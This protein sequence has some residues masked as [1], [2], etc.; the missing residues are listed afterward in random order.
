MR[1]RQLVFIAASSLMMAGLLFAGSFGRNAS[2]NAYSVGVNAYTIGKV[3]V[4]PGTAV[5]GGSV[6]LTGTG[7]L[8]SSELEVSMG[9]KYTDGQTYVAILGTATTDSQGNWSFKFNVPSTVKRLSDN[10]TV[11]IFTADWPVGGTAVGTDGGYYNSYNYLN[12]DTSRQTSTTMQPTSSGTST[13]S[14]TFVSA[15]TANTGGGA[16]LP[17]TGARIIA[18]ALAGI[19]FASVG[20]LALRLKSL[21]R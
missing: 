7:E 5:P 21:S 9:G 10:A 1:T 13:A 11:P 12:V 20:A 6:A 2:A 8:P 18:L 19:G 15:G 4:S 17:N 16:S 3:S 14:N